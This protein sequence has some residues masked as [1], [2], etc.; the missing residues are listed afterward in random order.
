[1]E[2]LAEIAKD[3]LVIMV[4]HN[5]ELAERY[6][7]RIVRLKDGRIIDDSDPFEGETRQSAPKPVRRVSMSFF[8]AL[9]LSFNNLRTKKGRTLL[10]SFAGSIGIIGIA[11]ILSL[12]TGIQGYVDSIQRDTLS[13]YPITVS[14]DDSTLLKNLMSSRGEDGGETG[15]AH[16]NDAVYSNANMYRLFNAAFADDGKE[17][18]LTA[19][20]AWLDREMSADTATT[21]LREYVSAVSYQYGVTLNTYVKGPDGSYRSTS[22][23]NAISV[24]GT[25]DSSQNA[26]STM[27]QSRLGA[28]NSWS[29]LLPGTDGELIS[30]MLCEQYELVEGKW[31]EA[32][33][34]IV[35]VLDSNNEISDISFYALGLM[36]DEEV[37]RMFMA[38]LSG[39][40]VVTEQRRISYSDVL[41]TTFRLLPSCDYYTRGTEGGWRDIREDENALQLAVQNGYTLKIVGILRPDPDATA[42]S[43]SGSFAYTQAL[44]EYIIEK[45][46][47]SE[48]VREQLLPENANY[49]VLRG[50]PFVMTA[51]QSPSESEKAERIRDYFASL[52]DEKKAELYQ[53]ILGTPT[54]EYLERTLGALLAQY[55]TR[56]S[57]L[58]LAATSYGVPESVVEAYF[59]DYSDEQLRS[60]LSAQLSKLITQKYA[61]QAALEVMQIKAAASTPDD[62]FGVGGTRAVAERFEQLMDAQDT[63]QLALWY[64]KYMPNTVSGSTLADTLAELGAVDPATPQSV[65]IYSDSFE[66]KE[67]IDALIADYNSSLPE[68]ERIT[69]T[70]YVALLMSGVTTM[71]NAVTYGLI[72]F[73]SI[74]LVV[75]SI[76]IGIITYI[77]VLERTKEIGIL[78]SVGA[79]RRDVSRVFNA[80]TVIVGLASG[81]IGIGVTLLLNIPISIIAKRLTGISGVAQLPAA[82]GAIL[83]VISVLLTVTA[84]LIPARMAA[85]KDPVI[86]LR[87]E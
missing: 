52:T 11:L 3:K 28:M 40:E 12:S 61:E 54:D 59:A 45:T 23:E 82:A 80:E 66:H 8:T 87:T 14:R 9:S 81:L 20:K 26:F 60:L 68:D 5:P 79:S 4:T 38:A 57:M 21:D 85:R 65:S 86:A 48:I 53:D 13:S 69:Y 19:F 63:A 43:V 84:G 7:T 70:D 50:L 78:R 72:G 42:A 46:A 73:V 10:T 25:A 67:S 64:D 24:G 39:E 49:D 51:A 41:G 22:I 74:S 62:I 76:M 17:N 34:E 36:S 1:M 16:G 31:P 58:T 6:S 29:E 30:P 2:L 35:L 71:I 33:D 37:N 27:L 47:N 32:A 83:V 75:S 18:D 56:E 15:A 44:T 55:P 77:S